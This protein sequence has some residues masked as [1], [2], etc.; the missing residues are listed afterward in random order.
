[1]EK[2]HQFLMGLDMEMFNVRSQILTLSKAYSMITRE[3]WQ[4]Q[5]IRGWEERTEIGAFHVSGG[6]KNNIKPKMENQNVGIVEILAMKKKKKVLALRLLLM[7][8][9]LA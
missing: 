2:L 4:K 3:E 6:T 1:M 8:S 9:K 5:V 7:L